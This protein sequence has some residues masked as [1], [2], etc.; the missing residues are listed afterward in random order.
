MK[1]AVTGCNGSVGRVT[2]RHV[3]EAGHSV[4][5]IDQAAPT[6]LPQHPHFSYIQAD[7][8]DYQE[9]LISLNGCDAVLHLAGI[10]NPQDFLVVAHNTNVTI[11]WNVLGCAAE[12]GI[13]RISQASSV[14][15][16]PMCFALPENRKFEYFPLDETHPCH[17]DEPYGL[18]KLICEMQADAITR[19]FS[20]M[21]IASFRLHWCVPE[22]WMADYKDPDKD[23]AHL[24]SYVRGDLCADAFLRGVC[25]P[26]ESWQ[27][28][29]A[30]FLAGPDMSL[31]GDPVEL[32]K[33]YW[34][35][36][37]IKPDWDVSTMGFFDCRKAERLLGWKH[38]TT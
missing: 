10:P 23:A 11:S 34:A 38:P 30:F 26:S 6:S 20:A 22:K 12:L 37:P 5:G 4:V 8:C 9:A 29:E 28:H 1:I 14:N 35:D 36:V 16:M 3:L 31:G 25:V 32:K 24:W 13:T 2:V 15:V 17:P 21:R 18:S 7:L 27:G 19:R 33:R